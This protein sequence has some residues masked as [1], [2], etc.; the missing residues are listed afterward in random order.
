[1][2]PLGEQVRIEF[3]ASTAVGSS[4]LQLVSAN[5]STRPLAAWE[6]LLIF[7]LSGFSVSSAGQVDVYTGKTSTSTAPQAELILTYSQAGYLSAFPEG[8]PCALGLVPKIVA[9][10]TGQVN[11][12]GTGGIVGQTQPGRPN[13]QANL[14]AGITIQP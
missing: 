12:T 3:S 14:T 13:W 11:L 2:H 8:F 5:G 9:P 7:N 4:T 1:M 10:S 6:R